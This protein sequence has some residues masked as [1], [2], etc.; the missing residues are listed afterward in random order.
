MENYV[1]KLV[2]TLSIKKCI[3]ID[4]ILD[5]G[6]FNGSYLTGGVLFLKEMEKRGMIKIKRISGCSIGALTGFLFY[7]DKLEIM[8]DLYKPIYTLLKKKHSLDLITKIGEI[9]KDYISDDICNIVNNRLYITYYHLSKRKKYIKSIYSDKNDII[10]SIIRSCFIPYLINGNFLYQNKYI[11]GINPFLFKPIN[12]RKIL[13]LDL[14]GI[15]KIQNIFNIKNEKTNIHRILSGMLEIH[16]FFIKNQNT[17]MCSYV[18]E[19]TIINYII[20][21]LKS[22][23]EKIIIYIAYIYSQF[24]APKKLFFLK[25][26]TYK[27]IQSLFI[28]LLEEYCV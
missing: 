14:F 18:N 8:I 24:K 3:S 28:C 26:I 1:T 25:K 23:I 21:L 11:D 17:S 20:Y 13:Y 19:W 27:M 5:G 15:D 10:D 9:L 16:N 12:G 4:L 6:I 7:I 22:F 2:E